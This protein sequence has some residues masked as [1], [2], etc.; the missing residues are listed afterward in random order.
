MLIGVFK[1][2][3]LGSGFELITNDKEIAKIDSDPFYNRLRITDE[4]GYEA[5][6][7]HPN[8]LGSSERVASEFTEYASSMTS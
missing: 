1:K 2:T 5:I 8:I 7:Y 3:F 4:D 6:V